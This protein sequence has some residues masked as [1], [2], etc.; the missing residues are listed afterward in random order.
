MTLAPDAIRNIA[1]AFVRDPDMGAA[2]GNIEI[3]W[4]IIEAR[5]ENGRLVLDENGEITV[6]ELGPIQRFLAKSQFLEYLSSF[7]L[8]RRSQ[9]ETET[10]YTLAGAC[11]AFRRSVLE[12]GAV[13]STVTVSEDTNLTFDLHKAGVKVGFVHDAKVYLEPVI[14]WDSLYAQRVRWTRG[15]LE[16]CGINEDLIDRKSV[17]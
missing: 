10:M 7:D 15:Q 8:G 11:S 5:D 6:A 16:V 2:T 3:D 1:K 4:E 9:A 17:V 13:Y 14:D 12:S